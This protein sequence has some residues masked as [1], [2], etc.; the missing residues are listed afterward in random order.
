MVH[1]WWATRVPS[2]RHLGHVGVGTHRP[3]AWVPHAGMLHHR[4]AS[5]RA[6]LHLTTI[7]RLPWETSWWHAHG[8]TLWEPHGH[9][10]WISL[11]LGV[12]LS[13]LPLVVQHANQMRWQVSW[14]RIPLLVSLLL[15]SRNP[16]WPGTMRT[17]LGWVL[18]PGPHLALHTCWHT[19]QHVVH[20]SSRAWRMDRLGDG[21]LTW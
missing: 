20:I 3:H 13:G 12:R 10:G 6:H 7:P 8:V 16:W 15:G 17:T 9:H 11:L 14:Q 1:L 2:G 21:S 19:M 4:V 18:H 5:P